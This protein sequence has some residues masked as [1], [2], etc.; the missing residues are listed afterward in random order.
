MTIVEPRLRDGAK[1]EATNGRSIHQRRHDPRHGVES[2]A[3]GDEPVSSGER[4]D[5]VGG[6][7]QSLGE[8]HALGL[9]AI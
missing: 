7:D 8:G 9:V 3:A 4:E 1:R 6:G 5:T 2:H